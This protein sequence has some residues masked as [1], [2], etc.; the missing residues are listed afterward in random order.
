MLHCHT[1]LVLLASVVGVLIVLGRLIFAVSIDADAPK[2]LVLKRRVDKTGVLGGSMAHGGN[3]AVAHLLGQ[4][5]RGK[6]SRRPPRAPWRTR[7]SSSGRYIFVDVFTGGWVQG[8]LVPM[9]KT[10]LG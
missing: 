7:A 6:G 1:S 10:T 5:D 2:S 4:W 3:D 8:T 9:E